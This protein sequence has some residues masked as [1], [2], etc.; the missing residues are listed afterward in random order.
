AASLVKRGGRLVYASCSLMR[1][2]NEE[3]AADFQQRHPQF[4]TVPANDVLTRRHIALT[5]PDNYLRLSPHRHGTDGF[6]AAI[7]DRGT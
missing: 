7:F 5:M 6:F 2:E 1:E 3:V 4:R